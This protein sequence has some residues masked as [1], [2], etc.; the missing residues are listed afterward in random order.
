MLDSWAFRERRGALAGMA[1]FISRLWRLISILAAM[2]GAL[3]VGL[4]V[5]FVL[6]RLSSGNVASFA[7][8]MTELRAFILSWFDRTH[9]YLP[10]AAAVV[11]GAVA[12]TEYT[13]V[14]EW[15]AHALTAAFC[16]ALTI[17]VVIDIHVLT[18]G[19]QIAT[20]LQT[21]VAAFI[22]GL[23]YWAVAGRAAGRWRL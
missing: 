12:F 21:L 19:N 17:F 15:V 7:M 3:L 14:R 1:Q 13:G 9:T 18:I 10:V 23:A 22:A 4:C 6:S 16:A 2:G 8:L 11:A 5:F 20:A